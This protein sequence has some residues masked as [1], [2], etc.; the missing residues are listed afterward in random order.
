MTPVNVFELEGQALVMAAPGTSE[1]E[2]VPPPRR[3]LRPGH[4]AV[5]VT[6][7]PA[8]LSTVANAVVYL[9]GAFAQIAMI[10]KFAFR[11]VP[12]L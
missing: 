1:V 9:R 6:W 8:G 4:V 7:L 5:V 11:V 2:S 12:L 3:T 10:T